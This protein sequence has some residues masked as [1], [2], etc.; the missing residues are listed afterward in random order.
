MQNLFA[1][2]YPKETLAIFKLSKSFKILPKGPNLVTLLTATF[3]CVL[4]VVMLLRHDDDDVG[5]AAVAANGR[6][7]LWRKMEEK[8]K[9]VEA[10]IYIVGK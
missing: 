5:R 9:I 1:K 2:L 3:S 8:V 10:K 6:L 7:K 4:D